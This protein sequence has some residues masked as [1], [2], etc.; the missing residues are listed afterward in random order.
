MVHKVFLNCSLR[1]LSM[2]SG[3]KTNRNCKEKKCDEFHHPE[4]LN[5]CT[6]VEYQFE[7]FL[8][9]LVKFCRIK[10]FLRTQTIPF[11]I[12][13]C[14][15][16]IELFLR[17]IHLSQ[18]INWYAH[19]SFLQ[20]SFCSQLAARL[21]ILLLQHPLNCFSFANR[22]KIVYFILNLNESTKLREFFALRLRCTCLSV[23]WHLNSN[24]LFR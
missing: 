22:E 13:T 11:L 16:L 18:C 20:L 5:D 4:K 9:K 24:D 17:T 23:S 10:L 2:D 12:Q 1:E 3:C 8:I 15:I 21:N 19:Y 14:E 6:Y 7:S